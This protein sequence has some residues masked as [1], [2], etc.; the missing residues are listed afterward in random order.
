MKAWRIAAAALLCLAGAAAAAQQ[1][2]EIR[3]GTNMAVAVTP[4]GQRIVVDLL[5]Q[6]WSLPVTGGG[7]EP[8]TPEHEEARN[9]RVSP[10]GSR[11]VYQRL[12]NGQWD[13]WLLDLATRERRALTESPY[14]ERE[15]D[16]MPSGDSVVFASNRTGHFCLWR[17]DVASGVLTQLTEEPGDA[18]F[19]AVSE[20]EQ[21]AYALARDGGSALRVLTP[22]G[23][24]VEL[25][26]TGRSL[27]APSWRPGDDV[28]V[29]HELAPG[30]SSELKMLLIADVPVIK[31]LTRAEDVF[32][33]RPAWL[34]PAELVYTADGQIWRR[35]LASLGREPVFLFAAITVQAAS[36]PR[37]AQPLDAPTAH[38]AAGIAG[39]S[40]SR[41]G[42]AAVFTA[43]GDLWLATRNGLERLTDDP[44]VESDPV[45]T[46]DGEH[47]IFASDRGGSMSLWRIGADG[48]AP[49]QLT[50]GPDKAY[51][52]SLAADGRT[53]S[54]LTTDG[55]GPWAPSVL[56]TGT[57]TAEGTLRQEPAPS[58][59]AALGSPGIDPA[60]GGLAPEAP[61]AAPA[62]AVDEAVLDA[63]DLE[64]S[65]APA[66]EPYVVQVGRLF[67]GVRAEYRRHVDIHVEGQRITAIVGRGLKPLPAKV[68]DA[69]DATVIPGLIDVHAHQSALAGERL[70]RA[71]LAYGV[72]TVREIADDL[73]AA[74][75]RGE[76]WASGRRPG[77]RLVVSPATVQ[78]VPPAAAPSPVLVQSFAGLGEGL[79]HRLWR[80]ARELGV[81]LWPD[82]SPPLPGG[83]AAARS[84]YSL[85]LSPLNASYQDSLAPIVASGTV[86][87]PTLAALY[88]LAEWQPRPLNRRL[89]DPAFAQLFGPA[90]RERWSRSR[91][92]GD[93]LAA[94]QD[95]VTRLVRSGG[96]VAIGTDAPAAPYGLGVHVEMQR[97][98]AAGIASD[99]VLRIATA[100]G[101]L[102]L[103]LEQQL[104]TLEEGKLADFVVLTGDPLTRIDDTLT[105]TA[106]VK[107][108][109]WFDREELLTA[110]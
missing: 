24:S 61:P 36:A 107:G 10:D 2:T 60:A 70:G 19:P 63:I 91:L 98:A 68:I 95:T 16:F 11:V 3:Q 83:P 65:V 9:P 7:A 43:L 94:L 28:L 22:Q 84:P 40:A 27:A 100:Q 8:L 105:I 50:T 64:W 44:F 103:G 51:R 71:W 25:V 104:G 31:P 75:E 58:V 78:S 48:T 108:G 96:R 6:L 86:V 85:E 47:V 41:D 80:Q 37:V 106:V 56:H 52:P 18:S 82:G 73:P 32:R 66:G 76:A 88:G 69:R 102:A 38:R 26:A 35:G 109:R 20:H 4:D 90:E 62:P 5:G 57:L 12:V 81:P 39:L 72:T 79:G 21:I 29:F 34:S 17:I 110:P 1:I 89:D 54:F 99:Q 93:T 92:A 53:L 42:R 55:L 87:V 49:R 77:P 30:R 46:P 33:A 45:L 97:L 101:A 15:P 67:D 59:R 23:V 14:D 13:L 74:L